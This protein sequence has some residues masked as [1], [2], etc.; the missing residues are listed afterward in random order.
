MVFKLSFLVLLLSV[1]LVVRCSDEFEDDDIYD[2]DA[3]D[4]VYDIEERDDSDESDEDTGSDASSYYSKMISCA[5]KKSWWAFSSYGCYCGLGGRG[6]PVDDVDRCCQTRDQCTAAAVS[7]VKSR[8]RKYGL[9]LLRYKTTSCT[10]CSTLEAYGDDKY[11]KVKHD[12]C[13]CDSAAAKCLAGAEDK[14]DRKYIRYR[15]KNWG[16]NCAKKS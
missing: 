12:L 2:L 13:Q 4:D 14:Y 15:L 6:T 8:W 1:S 16:R 3:G 11:A 5:T 9:R 7:E 10:E